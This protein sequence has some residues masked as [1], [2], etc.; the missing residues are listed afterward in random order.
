[1]I[2]TQ[3]YMKHNPFF[4]ITL[5]LL[6]L[7]L[8]SSCGVISR[9]ETISGGTVSSIIIQPLPVKQNT[10][11]LSNRVNLRGGDFICRRGFPVDE[12]Y[13]LD[14]EELDDLDPSTDTDTDT[15]TA[16]NQNNNED[17]RQ[18]NVTTTVNENWFKMGLYFK[19]DSEYYLV[20]DKI[21]FYIKANYGEETLEAQVLDAINV[22]YCGANSEFMPTQALY[23]IPPGE[24]V[25][26]NEARKNSQHNLTLYVSGVPLPTGPKQ[27][28]NQP[29]NDERNTDTLP[30]ILTGLPTYNVKATLYGRLTDSRLED[31]N[32]FRKTISFVIPPQ[33]FAQ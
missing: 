11:I 4:L 33:R 24:T 8:T 6:H 31:Q 15:E 23:I 13:D 22:S 27:Q 21:D 18:D 26:Y 17:A 12:I 10:L 28:R 1:M 29:Q 20:I 32:E 14:L 2:R 3:L 7:F 5:M 16:N 19:N 30:F 25:S 9:I